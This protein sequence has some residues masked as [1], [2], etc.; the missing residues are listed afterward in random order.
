MGRHRRP[1]ATQIVPAEPFYR[2]ED[3]HQQYLKK[4]GAD[5]CSIDFF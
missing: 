5:S 3:Y 4:R 1:I 2:A